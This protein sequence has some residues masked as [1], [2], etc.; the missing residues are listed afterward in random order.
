VS[1]K[2]ALEMKGRGTIQHSKILRAENEK[3]K[4]IS[5]TFF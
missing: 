1:S 5:Y 2:W 3:G 4:E